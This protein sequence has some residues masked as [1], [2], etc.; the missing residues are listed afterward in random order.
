MDYFGS[1]LVLPGT[2]SLGI[3]N[4]LQLNLVPKI[5]KLS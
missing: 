4:K 5:R 3:E 1:L 2:V